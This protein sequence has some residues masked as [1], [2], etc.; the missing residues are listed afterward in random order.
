MAVTTFYVAA[1][2]T[3]GGV[4]SL[5]DPMILGGA[6]FTA[7]LAAETFAAN[8]VR[9]G[10]LPGTHVMAAAITPAGTPTIDNVF[11]CVAVDGLGALLP[12][13]TYAAGA[14]GEWAAR[15]FDPEYRAQINTSSQIMASKAHARFSGLS[16]VSTYTGAT[17]LIILGTSALIND[18]RF[19]I[20]SIGAGRYVI[21]FAGADAAVSGSIVKFATSAT[22]YGGIVDVGGQGSDINDCLFIGPATSGGAGNRSGIEVSGSGPRS[23]VSNCVVTRVPGGGI[24]GTNAA[25]GTA[26]LNC[27]IANVGGSGIDI[28]A[29]PSLP[30]P[31]RHCH[32][33]GCGAWGMDIDAAGFDITGVIRMRNNGTGDINTANMGDRGSLGT[34]VS[35]AGSDATD[36]VDA[37]NFDFRLK[38][39]NPVYGLGVGIGDSAGTTGGIR[40]R[41]G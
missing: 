6:S 35:T 7:M 2:G 25:V 39:S 5:I 29:T 41:G 28:Q 19:G 17:S 10:F 14:F 20:S 21:S 34:L 3:G 13:P 23:S 11:E 36:F 40:F 1:D 27:T 8:A 26:V 24:V 22:S 38:R 30:V 33:T 9:I 32:I 4:G 31:V 18:C 37:T 15:E 12:E 16:F